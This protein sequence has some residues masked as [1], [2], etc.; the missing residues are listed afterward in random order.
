MLFQI[1]FLPPNNSGRLTVFCACV[2]Y[3]PWIAKMYGCNSR[4][5]EFQQTWAAQTLWLFR[6]VP[7]PNSSSPCGGDNIPSGAGRTF[8]SLKLNSRT[9]SSSD[10][11]VELSDDFFFWDPQHLW[12]WYFQFCLKIQ[13]SSCISKRKKCFKIQ[14]TKIWDIVKKS[15][16]T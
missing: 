1:W 10:S 14:F 12:S 5:H 8:W 3:R 16:D 13:K 15:L 2:W 7:V 6:D 4:C 11:I 9:V